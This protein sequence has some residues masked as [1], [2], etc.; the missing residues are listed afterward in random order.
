MLKLG[1]M[2]VRARPQSPAAAARRPGKLALWSMAK[3]FTPF[4]PG[5]PVGFELGDLPTGAPDGAR[6]RSEFCNT[7]S[8]LY[9][10]TKL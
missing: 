5:A 1:H 9:W 4:I 8:Y 6:H 3:G 10:V 2:L 7:G